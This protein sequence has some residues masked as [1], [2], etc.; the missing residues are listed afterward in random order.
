MVPS[1]PDSGTGNGVAPS[2]NRCVVQKVG[3]VAT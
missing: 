1:Y 2:G 3:V